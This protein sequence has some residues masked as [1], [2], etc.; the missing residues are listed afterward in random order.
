MNSMNIRPTKIKINVEIEEIFLDIN[1]AIP[2]GLIINELVSN[3]LKY[4]F[5]ES[6]S[7]TITI[8]INIDES[9]YILIISDDGIG[10]PDN[11][12]FNDTETLGMQLVVTLV[13]QIKGKI[14]LDNSNGTFFRI[15]FKKD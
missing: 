3:S 1:R 2:C 9:E 14:E 15:N 13:E 8:S 7:G 5:P 10:F 11:I 6:M 4:A 12:K